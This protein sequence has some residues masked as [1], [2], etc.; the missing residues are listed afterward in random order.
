MESEIFIYKVQGK[1]II[2]ICN[3][4]KIQITS[5]QHIYIHVFVHALIPFFSLSRKIMPKNICQITTYIHTCL[6]AC[7]HSI[8]LSLKKNHAIKKTL[9]KSLPIKEKKMKRRKTKESN[10]QKKKRKNVVLV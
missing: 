9:K 10:H 4:K 6:R 8:P 3:L 1:T 2:L 5:S 7:P